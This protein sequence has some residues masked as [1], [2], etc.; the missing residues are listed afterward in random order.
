MAN[1]SQQSKKFEREYN[2]GSKLYVRLSSRGETQFR[3]VMGL[4]SIPTR[5]LTRVGEVDA[6]ELDPVPESLD[7]QRGPSE[8]FITQQLPGD[9][10]FSQVSIMLNKTFRNFVPNIPDLPK[11]LQCCFPLLQNLYSTDEQCI[12]R[13]NVR[14]GNYDL[15]EGTVYSLSDPIPEGNDLIK[16][17]MNILPCSGITRVLAAENNN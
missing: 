16:V 3:R 6:T 5:E 11:D 2:K 8:F 12:W 10:K 13:I 17:T 9:K 7:P 14:S 15:F 1:N 4:L